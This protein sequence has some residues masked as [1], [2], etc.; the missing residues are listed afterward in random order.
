MRNE[1]EGRFQKGPEGP[2]GLSAA[3][4]PPRCP[5]PG[6]RQPIHPIYLPHFPQGPTLGCRYSFL[7]PSQLAEQMRETVRALTPACKH[8]CVSPIPGQPELHQHHVPAA[9]GA[10]ARGSEERRCVLK[11][12]VQPRR[13]QGVLPSTCQSPRCPL[14]HSRGLTN[15]HGYIPHS[16][17][18][19]LADGC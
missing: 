4:R 6:V 7:N 18:D 1:Q 19:R 15:G 17:V 10:G 2:T 3:C 16:Q 9:P 14:S 8:F 13:A 12:L 11:G 5:R